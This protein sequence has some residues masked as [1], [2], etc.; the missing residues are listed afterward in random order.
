MRRALTALVLPLALA[1]WFSA[2]AG[3]DSAPN[4]PDRVAVVTTTTILKDLVTNVGG[5]RVTV[6]ALLD[7]G[8]EPHD[9][10]PSTG[11]AAAIAG[12]DVV[13]ESGLGID[14][15]TDGVISGSGSSARRVLAT[16]GIAAGPTGDPH[17]WL[18]PRDA[19]RMVANIRDG[20]A[21]AD[22]EGA[23]GYRR[24]AAAYDRTLAALDAEISELIDAVPRRARLLVAAH[25]GYRHLADRYGIT[26]VG[27]VTSSTSAAAEPSARDVA[28]L[29]EAVRERHVRVVFTEE[30]VEPRIERAIAESAGVPLGPALFSDSLGSSD[31]PAGTYVGMMRTNAE[32]LVAGFIS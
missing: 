19:R 28:R 4:A 29:A 32:R 17:V 30:T 10:E 5:D 22:P 26:T 31:G 2:C 3:S 9:Y 1:C 20:L 25:D 27:S 6:R 15:W 24:N 8:A 7:V 16:T 12:A 21:A 23:T 14:S 11:D 18:D 13:V